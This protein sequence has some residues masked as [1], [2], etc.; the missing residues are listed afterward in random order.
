MLDPAIDTFLT[1]RKLLWL[2]KRISVQATEKAD[3]AIKQQAE[4]MFSLS[5]WLPDAAKR[6][7][8][9]YAVTHPGKFSHPNAR[10]SPVLAQPA[11]KNDGFLRSGNADARLDVYGNAASLDVYK[12]LNIRLTGGQSILWHLEQQTPFIKQQCNL[13]DAAFKKVTQELLAIKKNGAAKM[14][15]GENIK[16]VYFPIGHGNYHLLSVLT[17]SGLMFKIKKRINALRF[18]HNTHPAQQ[19]TTNTAQHNGS[20]PAKF[21]LY[22]ISF[23]G[24]KPQNIS[25]LNSQNGGTAFL[26]PSLP[27]CSRSGQIKPPEYSF[28]DA[29]LD[30][31]SYQE[32]FEQWHQ[33]IHTLKQNNHLT[34]RKKH[35]ALTRAIV[36]LVADRL[37][38]VRQLDAGWSRHDNCRKL[39][40]HEKIWLDQLYERTRKLEP[41]YLAAIKQS[42]INWFVGTYTR[43][44]GDQ[45]FYLSGR[46][47]LGIRKQIDQCEA[48]LR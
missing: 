25:I 40:R 8:Q 10:I 38:Q 42:L 47:L 41:D 19:P 17:P 20:L 6:A 16:Q 21:A 22:V 29:Y 44:N 27:P 23:G 3:K 2:K 1:E 48:A 35:N 24:T 26:L 31:R 37:W 4:E 32:A 14:T 11:K 43:I 13:S 39:P 30:R 15:T 12:F 9:L 28:F 33:Q 18:A 7:E 45:A 36:Y 34:I 5:N 46:V